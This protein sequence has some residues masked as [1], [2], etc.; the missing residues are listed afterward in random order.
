M[1]DERR[2]QGA[3]NRHARRL[4][5]GILGEKTARASRATSGLAR[6]PVEGARALTDPTDENGHGPEEHAAARAA[7]GEIAREHGVER[8]AAIG[9][10]RRSRTLR[11]LIG[12]E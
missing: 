5:D 6:A 8:A 12:C 4:R 1:R 2:G 10:A 9:E 3:R 11:D 7:N